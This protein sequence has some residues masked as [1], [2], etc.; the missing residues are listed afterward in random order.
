MK[1]L[2]QRGKNPV[3]YHTIYLFIYEGERIFDI[4]L[5]LIE[6]FYI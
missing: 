6:N 2:Y 1:L 3:A 4:Y 5:F